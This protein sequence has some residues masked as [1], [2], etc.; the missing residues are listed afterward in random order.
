MKNRLIRLLG[1][2]TSEEVSRLYEMNIKLEDALQ[3]ERK[4]HN[5]VRRFLGKRKTSPKEKIDYFIIGQIACEFKTIFIDLITSK[6]KEN[7]WS[8]TSEV[9]TN[10]LQ[11]SFYFSQNIIYGKTSSFQTVCEDVEAAILYMREF[12]Y[13]FNVRTIKR[14]ALIEFTSLRLRGK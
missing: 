3:D 4:A 6:A 2:T 10:E 5:R 12:G 14:A 11:D 8:F 9:Y 13:A 7:D 1:G